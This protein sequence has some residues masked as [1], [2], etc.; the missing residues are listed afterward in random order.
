M[1]MAVY[2]GVVKDNRVMLDDG[3]QLADGMPVEIRPGL[4]DSGSEDA[5]K[6]RLLTE[7]LLTKLPSPRSATSTRERQL[8][9]VEGEPLS[10]MI[11]AERR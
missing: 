6:K 9:S 3:V 10:R 11:I 1:C 8:I 4:P 5:F 7:G 2:Y